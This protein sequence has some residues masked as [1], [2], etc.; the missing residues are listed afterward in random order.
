MEDAGASFVSDV[1]DT[2]TAALDVL[3]A[4]NLCGDLVWC[5]IVWFGV[6]VAHEHI[7]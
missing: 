7:Y 3:Q 6:A 2:I 4:R 5:G 1:V